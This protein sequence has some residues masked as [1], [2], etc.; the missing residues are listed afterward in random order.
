MYLL[1]YLFFFIYKYSITNYSPTPPVPLYIQ[2]L[3][4]FNNF[5]PTN[6]SPIPPS[7]HITSILGFTHTVPGFRLKPNLPTHPLHPSFYIF[8]CSTSSRASSP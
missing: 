8:S 7:K 3:N 5:K 2:L 4:I 1:Y 6:N